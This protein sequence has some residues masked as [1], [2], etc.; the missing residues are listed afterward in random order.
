VAQRAVPSSRVVYADN[1]P[2]V[3]AHARAL[4]TSTKEGR[5]AYIRAD[6]RDPAAVP[7]DP[8]TQE[9]LDFSQPVAL[10]LAAV[11]HFVP[12]ED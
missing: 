3:L 8:V 10:V 2:M 11:L 6:L 9:V 12:D 4:L 1:D 5:S 7:A